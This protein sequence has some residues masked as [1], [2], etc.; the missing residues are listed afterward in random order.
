[1][2]RFA[3]LKEEERVD[4][5]YFQSPDF[6]PAF[7]NN[8]LYIEIGTLRKWL[9]KKTAFD[10]R[11]ATGHGSLGYIVLKIKSKIS[12]RIVEIVFNKL[13]S[14]QHSIRVWG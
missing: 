4:G 3:V 2:F 7:P 11:L 14:L 10:V 6:Y 13:K 9:F 12:T 8:L 1:M 5:W